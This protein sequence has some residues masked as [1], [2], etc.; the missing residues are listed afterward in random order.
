MNSVI[1]SVVETYL[2]AYRELIESERDGRSITL[3]LPFHLA[4]NH[5]IEITVTDLG[6]NVCIVSDSARTLGEIEAAGYSL[7]GQMKQRLASIA[8]ASGLRVIDSNLILESSYAELGNSIQKFLEVSKMIGDVYLVHRQRAEAGDGLLARVKTV[9]DSTNIRYLQGQKLHGKIEDHSVD[10]LVSPNGHRGLAVS[11]LGGQNTHALAQIWYGKC[12]DIRKARENKN[13][14]IALVYD[15]SSGVW[16][17]ASKSWLAA[18]ADVVLPGN[19]LG[20]LPRHLAAQGVITHA[21][22]TRRRA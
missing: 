1:D 8:S 6:G 3:S 16:S 4:A 10:L 22:S 9:I 5:R 17:D 20:E 7:T 11:V 2:L 13:I 18:K 19:S 14:K 15:V 12:D 21:R